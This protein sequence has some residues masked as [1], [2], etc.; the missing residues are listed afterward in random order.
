MV[1]VGQGTRRPWWASGLDL[2][3]ESC[4]GVRPGKLMSGASVSNRVWPV[5]PHTG[6]DL[7]NIAT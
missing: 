4:S 6:A 3:R 2:Q 7:A 1:P 5:R